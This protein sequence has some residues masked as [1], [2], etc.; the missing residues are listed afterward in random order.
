MFDLRQ[1][2]N[3]CCTFCLAT[4][5]VTLQEQPSL[6]PLSLP[7]NLVKIILFLFCRLKMKYNC[8]E[9]SSLLL[10]AEFFNICFFFCGRKCRTGIHRWLR[11]WHFLETLKA[12]YRKNLVNISNFQLLV[13]FHWRHKMKYYQD[14]SVVLF[15]YLVFGLKKASLRISTKV[16][17][18]QA[19]FSQ[20]ITGKYSDTSYSLSGAASVVVVVVFIMRITDKCNWKKFI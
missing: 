12:N 11:L 1:I 20:Q 18:E 7:P 2:C 5:L 9:V 16:K 13:F 19:G 4:L 3:F 6:P 8:C 10:E 17:V 14:S 15:A